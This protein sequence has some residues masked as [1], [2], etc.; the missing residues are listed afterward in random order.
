MR[1]V[2]QAVSCQGEPR[3]ED[4]QGCAG[5]VV[6][7]DPRRRADRF[8]SQALA[9]RARVPCWLVLPSQPLRVQQPHRAA[10]VVKAAAADEPV[11]LDPLET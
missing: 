11:A 10:L 4:L 9:P 8:A 3:R 5:W 1:R 6:A 2:H 7:P